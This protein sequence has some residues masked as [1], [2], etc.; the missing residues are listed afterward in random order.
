MLSYFVEYRRCR[1]VEGFPRQCEF[2]NHPPVPN[3]PPAGSCPNMGCRPPPLDSPSCCRQLPGRGR[4]ALRRRHCHQ[5]MRRRLRAKV[6]SGIPVMEV[7]ARVR[8]R[9]LDHLRIYRTRKRPCFAYLKWNC[10]FGCVGCLGE[11][12]NLICSHSHNFHQL[13]AIYFF[14]FL[15]PIFSQLFLKDG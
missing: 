5:C 13:R 4:F 7:L 6:S 10:Y 11:F 15:A 12:Q 9:R 2:Q 3:S 14:I 8:S 1:V